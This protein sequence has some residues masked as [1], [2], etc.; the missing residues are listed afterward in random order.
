MKYI[1]GLLLVFIIG[2]ASAQTT[3]VFD[4]VYMKDGRVLYGE[5][6]NFEMKDGDI[7]FKERD[8]RMYSITREEYKYFIEDQVYKKKAKDTL[9]NTRKFNEFEFE[10]GLSLHYFSYNHS[11]TKDN[12]YLQSSWNGSYGIIPVNIHAGFGKYF[13]RKWY[14]GVEIEVT[15]FSAAKN[16]FL[17]GITGRYQY[18]SHRTD[19]A[20]YIC[21]TGNYQT[22]VMD[23]EYQVADSL[24]NSSGVKEY[25]GTFKKDMVFSGFN[26]GIGHGFQFQFLFLHSLNLELSLYKQF[27]TRSNLI[28]VEGNIPNPSSKFAGFGARLMVAYHF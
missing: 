20:K 17:A 7:T 11:F 15:A 9:I 28:N 5:I 19:V 18:D 4:V 14:A 6:I 16:S 12:Y 24:P 26:L 25:P 22:M 23:V 3:E 1:I 13:K 10:A 8:G 21:F 27:G 2:Q